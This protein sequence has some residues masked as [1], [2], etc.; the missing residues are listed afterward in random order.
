[1]TPAEEWVQ[2]QSEPISDWPFQPAALWAW[3]LVA[4]VA[5]GL[6]QQRGTA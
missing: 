2:A 6:W 5:W 4:L 1:M 3:A